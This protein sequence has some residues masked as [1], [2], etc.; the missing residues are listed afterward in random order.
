MRSFESFRGTPRNQLLERIGPAQA[1]ETSEVPVGG[2][3]DAAVLDGQ[4]GQVGVTD[5]RPASL[6]LQQ[7]LPEQTPMLISGCQETHVGLLQPLIHNLDDFLGR[8]PLSGESWVGDDSEKGRHRL[9][10]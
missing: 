6:A 7:H 2:V 8:E 5:Q 9:P 3:E 4:R 10:W 1:G